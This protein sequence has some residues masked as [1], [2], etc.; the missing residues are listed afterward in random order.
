MMIISITFSMYLNPQVKPFTTKYYLTFWGLT[1]R[2]EVFLFL[3][4]IKNSYCYSLMLQ[5]F[6]VELCCLYV[7]MLI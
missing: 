6:V 2:M 4:N 5:I 3:N 7:I 1:K